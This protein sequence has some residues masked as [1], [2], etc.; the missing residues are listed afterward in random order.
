MMF[1]DMLGDHVLG[2]SI[3]ASGRLE[4]LG[5]YVGYENRRHRWTWGTAVQQIPYTTGGFSQGLATV[6]GEQVF[7]EQVEIFREIHRA[8]EAYIA[9]PFSRAQRVELSG[10]IRNIS[11]QRELE[12]QAVSVRTGDLVINERR[13]LDA[14][15]GLTMGTASA[16]LVYDTSIFGVASPIVG[17]RYRLEVSPMVGTVS[18]TGLLADYRKYVMPVRPYT[19]AFRLLHYGRYG[20]GGE[21]D[22][23]QPLFLGY[24][25]L[26][27]G[28]DFGSFSA[29]ECGTSSGSCPVFD[30]LLGSRLAVANVELRFPP[31]SALGGRRFYGPLPL[32]LLAFAD[33][34]AAWTSTEKPTFLGGD[35]KVVGSYGAGARVNVL[36]FVVVE[37]DY[38]RPLDRPLQKSL[39]QFNFTTGF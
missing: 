32:E 22:R 29:E 1:S 31:F 12:T 7:V 33:A 20:S 11:F 27:R 10:G 8:A 21:D 38:V 15:S 39:W 37:V 3:Q 26:V 23:L 2:A 34:G 19:L 25:N 30:R 16:A 4:D 6:N 13:D 5:G 9:Y 36:G 35:R 18:F 14:P 24:P 28:Y 17:Q